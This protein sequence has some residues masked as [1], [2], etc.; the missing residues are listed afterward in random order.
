MIKK[1]GIP[2]LWENLVSVS[3]RISHVD[4]RRLSHHT[5]FYRIT[6]IY[7]ITFFYQSVNTYFF[8]LATMMTKQGLVAI[9]GLSF[10]LQLVTAACCRSNQCLKG[11]N[12]LCA[13]SSIQDQ[14]C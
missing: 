3:S 2:S 9:L 11:A 4:L 10:G 13:S 5:R 6:L 1:D 7:C 8:R 14:A 12:M